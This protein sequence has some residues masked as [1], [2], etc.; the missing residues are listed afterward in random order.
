MCAR[1]D[2]DQ[3]D[4]STSAELPDT[5]E[6]PLPPS[7]TGAAPPPAV[8]PNGFPDAAQSAPTTDPTEGGPWSDPVDDLAPDEQPVKSQSV[9]GPFDCYVGKVTGVFSA[10]ADGQWGLTQSIMVKRATY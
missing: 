10:S 1:R 9:I 2:D 6:Q 8:A 4:I 7:V 3:F 5:R